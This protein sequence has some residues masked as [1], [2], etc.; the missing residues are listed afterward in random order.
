MEEEILFFK[1]GKADF[2]SFFPMRLFW[3]GCM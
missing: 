2:P 3:N 1:E